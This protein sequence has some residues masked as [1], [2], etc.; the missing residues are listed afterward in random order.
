MK[1]FN[2]IFLSIFLLLHIDSHQK[3]NQIIEVEHQNKTFN[4]QSEN[5]IK[6]D[7]VKFKYDTLIPI[8][9]DLFL[10]YHKIDSINYF[11]Y[12]KNIGKNSNEFNYS[13]EIFSSDT[14]KWGVID[15]LGNVVIPFICDGIKEISENIGVL[16]VFYASSSHHTGVPRYNYIG[17]SYFFNKNGLIP[18]PLETFFTITIENI[19]DN[20]NSANVIQLGPAFFLPDEYRTGKRN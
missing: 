15:S 10:T 4:I 20:H 11:S 12:A 5:K 17:K 13:E 8:F 2:F 9:D 1:V 18:K 14:K 7:S 3:D 16:S 19:A 6:Y